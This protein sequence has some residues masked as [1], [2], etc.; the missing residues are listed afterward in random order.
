MS[1]TNHF[2]MGIYGQL[3][4]WSIVMLLLF[5]AKW[6]WSRKQVSQTEAMEQVGGMEALRKA[7]RTLSGRMILVA[8]VFWCI[9]WG[10]FFVLH[11][12][13]HFPLY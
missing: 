2:V 6:N 3:L 11:L 10:S 1:A 8:W 7:K 13:I 9:L 4:L 12:V 5:T